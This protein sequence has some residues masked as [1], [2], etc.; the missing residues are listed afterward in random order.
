MFTAK[1][2]PFNIPMLK[3]FE[4]SGL[5]IDVHREPEGVR[6]TLRLS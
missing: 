1:V 6:V 2:L 4:Q 5:S 3:G